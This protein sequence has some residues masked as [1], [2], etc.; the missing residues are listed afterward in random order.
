MIKIDSLKLIQD[1]WEE[2]MREEKRIKE[3]RNN[4]KNGNNIKSGN[5]MNTYQVKYHQIVSRDMVTDLTIESELEPEEFKKK[6]E[7]EGACDYLYEFLNRD[8]SYYDITSNYDDV[9]GLPL[10][11]VSHIT[12]NGED[13]PVDVGGELWELR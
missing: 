12:K 7:G 5:G 8:E 4:R 11:F 13:V 6:L 10:N 3:K 2:M 1:S 9:D